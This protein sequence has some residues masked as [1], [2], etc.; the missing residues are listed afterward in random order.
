LG[1][2]ISDAFLILREEAAWLPR[3]E[4]L[5]LQQGGTLTALVIFASLCLVALCEW[6][7]PRRRPARPAAARRLAN[8]GFWVVNLGLAAVLLEPLARSFAWLDAIASLRVPA[9]PL[10]DRWLGP[11]AGFV[12]LD[13]LRYWVHR[14]EHAVPLLWRCHAMHHSDPDVDVT[15]AVRHH[16]IEYLLAS[17]VYWL[18]VLVLDIPAVAALVH[19]LTVFALA[20]VQHG[21]IRLPQ[22]LE[23]SLQPILMTTDL[24]R[25]HHSVAPGHADA[26]Y[27]AVLSV[28]DRLFG[29]HVAI[30]RA[31]Q[32]E[33]VFGVADLPRRECTRPAPMLLT[34]WLIGRARRPEPARG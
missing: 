7:R 12:L 6:R 5:R 4:A 21:N 15:T 19:G 27:G 8:L 28:W 25:V 20:A 32:D 26:N 3:I 2:K 30:A 34:P 31:Q 33:I 14:C 24:H 18:A 11:A 10:A 16:P 23:R 13:L 1:V 17:A 29:T 22:V 9:S